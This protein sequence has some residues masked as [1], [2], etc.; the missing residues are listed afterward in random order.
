MR[1][2]VLSCLMSVALVS[3][4]AAGAEPLVI[5]RVEQA[6][7]IDGQPTEAEWSDAAEITL[8]P[9]TSGTN[10]EP[11]P[12]D[13]A[14]TARVMYDRENLYVAF[15]C[16]EPYIEDLR[17]GWPHIEERDNRLW[18]DDCVE[19]FLD[20]R[21]MN[22]PD[23]TAPMVH[24]IANSA[25]VWYDAFE[26]DRTYDPELTVFSEVHEESWTV[27]IAIP[28]RDLG[29]FP[30]GGEIW[31]ANFARER[32]AR[33]EISTWGQGMGNLSFPER[34][35]PIQFAGGGPVS[36][37]SLQHRGQD[38]V[39]LEVENPLEEPAE[40]AASLAV[41]RDGKSA[42]PASET[43][44]IDAGGHARIEL[45]YPGAPGE[46]TLKLE[47][48][49]T[50]PGETTALY[51]NEFTLNRPGGKRAPRVWQID[52]PLYEGLLGDEPYLSIREGT[53]YW[54]HSGLAN[55]MLLMGIQYGI[56][57]KV[58]E[59]YRSLAANRLAP[60][61]N[62]GMIGGDFFGFKE[63][64][65]ELGFKFTHYVKPYDS[66]WPQ[67]LPG[68]MLLDE[69]C[70]EAYLE[71]ARKV[72]R[73]HGDILYAT[74]FGDEVIDHV[75]QYVVKLFHEHAEQYPQILEIDRHIR[76]TY[77]GGKWG[78]PHGQGDQTPY[79]WIATRK[80]LSAE[81]IDL[82]GELYQVVQEENPDVK[83]VSDDSISFPHAYDYSRFKGRCDIV[84]HQ[85]YP[86]NDAHMADFGFFVKFLADLTGVEDVC[87]V[88]HVEN[89]AVSGTA[90]E[91]LE[92][93]SQCVRN[94]GTGFQ[95]YLADTRGS[96]RGRGSLIHERWVG[97]RRFQTLLNVCQEMR[98]SSRPRYPE[99]D[100]AILYSTD[101][102]GG[103]PH[104][105]VR[106]TL[107]CGYTLLGPAAGGWMKFIDDYQL[108]RGEADLSAY[109]AIF[110]PDARY[111]RVA[112]IDALAAYVA[113]GGVLVATDPKVFDRTDLG[114]DASARRE[115]LFGVTVGETARHREI[116]D[117]EDRMA[118]VSACYDVTPVEDAKVLARFEDGSPAIVE[119]PYGKGRCIYFAMNPAA[120]RGVRS[121]NWKAYMKSLLASLG[122]RTDLAIWRFRFPESLIP[123]EPTFQGVCLTGNHLL[124]RRGDILPVANRPVKGTYTYSRPPQGK[125]TGGVKDIPFSK[126]DLTDRI[127]APKA[128]DIVTQRLAPGPWVSIYQD[129]EP[130]EITFD[131]AGVE[132]LDR[133]RLWYSHGP[134][135]EMK[136]YCREGTDGEWILAGATPGDAET[137]Y[138]FDVSDR[139]VSLQGIEAR[140]VKLSFGGLPPKKR[141]FLV[142]V[143][144]WGEE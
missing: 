16:E 73:E 21:S 114:E 35:R 68:P 111:E 136:V 84:A 19:I 1:H 20:V 143:E 124:A 116:V 75:E 30:K 113:E 55:R 122:C 90:E 58:Q 107:M 49:R 85:L 98:Q 120:S 109:Q 71:D 47:V 14:T 66:G 24:V 142:E 125:D 93:L 78:I 92:L 64:A 108:E 72:L 129:T 89:Y 100:F 115:E 110:L 69:R 51:E 60:L 101:T 38:I 12:L 74:S 29:F 31:M 103:Y 132:T 62:S 138:R 3:I 131:L 82:L 46:Q 96:R 133:V 50:G 76:E 104:L 119:H 97:P 7:V 18:D 42:E 105:S 112:A 11:E 130:L 53:V 33:P 5:P 41:I 4:S 141:T 25:G 144:I 79:R 135:P 140:Q 27:E 43:L 67:E 44:R 123:P 52:S 121:N 127:H 23:R 77:G 86:R 94:G 37:R 22:E 28:F 118:I 39:V 70:R 99:P 57:Y 87:P 102:I 126:G 61:M 45:P 6:P 106:N 56:R 40:I 137:P 139:T 26:G 9:F 34:Y 54:Y 32:K 81:L 63:A 13:A 36:V 134:L 48:L 59:I 15:H 117:G 88:A 10:E 95:L 8:E 2:L 83:V 80:W 17:V 128:G 91:V 65:R